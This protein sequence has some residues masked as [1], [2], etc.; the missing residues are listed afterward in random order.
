MCPAHRCKAG[1]LLYRIHVWG[2]EGSFGHKKHT[3]QEQTE[4]KIQEGQLIGRIVAICELFGNLVTICKMMR[5]SESR[6]FLR[7]L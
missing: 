6:I 1:R 4:K 7:F 2:F 3:Q 5:G